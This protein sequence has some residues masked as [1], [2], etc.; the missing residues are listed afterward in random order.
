M[1][2]P[3][4]PPSLQPAAAPDAPATPPAPP[5]L[6]GD[7]TVASVA[8]QAPQSPQA[9]AWYGET[10]GQNPEFVKDLYESRWEKTGDVWDSLREQRKISGLNADQVMPIPVPGKE[11]SPE[12]MKALEIKQGSEVY[13]LKYKGNDWERLIKVGGNQA[14]DIDAFGQ[15]QELCRKLQCTPIQAQ[16]LMDH[17]VA[18][19]DSTDDAD[20]KI[21]EA[22]IANSVKV[23]KLE[24][25]N[26]YDENMELVKMVGKHYQS[27]PVSKSYWDVLEESG[28][29]HNPDVVKYHRQMAED[30]KEGRIATGIP[31]THANMTPQKAA[32][33]YMQHLSDA[34]YR[35]RVQAG[36]PA[37]EEY[38]LALRIHQGIDLE[39][40]QR[41]FPD[42][43]P[44]S[45]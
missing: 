25:G 19:D 27:D 37:A 8:P 21:R 10:L 5:S 1:D 41:E 28:L 13:P 34:E 7:V 16:G 45:Y 36:G 31:A 43:E 33:I 6:I 2:T 3:A 42:E 38:K 39:A 11:M 24:W 18:R 9:P 17:L 35:A 15:V 30:M 4:T 12:L 20:N 22:E 40:H 44:V 32:Q 26:K 23:L 14:S 29:N